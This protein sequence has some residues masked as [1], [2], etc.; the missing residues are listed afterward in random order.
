MYSLTIEKGYEMPRQSLTA[1]GIGFI[2]NP[3]VCRY[4]LFIIM[5]RQA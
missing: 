1:S 2:D 3:F 4:T 5:T